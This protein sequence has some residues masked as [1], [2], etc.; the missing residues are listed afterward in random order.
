M[1]FKPA[2]T[3]GE[4]ARICRLSQ[5]TIIR[6]FDAGVLEGYRVPDSRVRRIPHNKLEKFIVDHALSNP[7]ARAVAAPASTRP[8]LCHRRQ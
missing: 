3:T 5:T 7:F 8:A 2:Y 6:L 1:P 4:A